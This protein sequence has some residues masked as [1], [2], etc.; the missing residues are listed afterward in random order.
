MRAMPSPSAPQILNV[1]ALV[2]LVNYLANKSL[3]SRTLDGQP[4]SYQKTGLRRCGKYFHH[5]YYFRNSCLIL[6]F[7]ADTD[8][9]QGFR[10][11]NNPCPIDDVQTFSLPLRK[12]LKNSCRKNVEKCR[13][14]VEKCRKET[15]IKRTC[16][17]TE[18]F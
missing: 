13:K 5:F 6:Q 14:D 4:I 8:A 9:E 12:K 10:R 11:L 17:L 1:A 15:P 2:F 18:S 16:F 7:K 3:M